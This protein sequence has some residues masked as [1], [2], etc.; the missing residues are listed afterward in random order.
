MLGMR[1]FFHRREQRER[2]LERELRAHLDLESEDLEDADAARRAFGNLARAREMVREEWGFMWLERF[3]KNL[4][5]AFR[6]M[7]RSP[8]FTAIAIAT[9][10]LGLGATSAMFTIVNTALLEPLQYRDPGRLYI[11]RTVPPAE[12]KLARDFPLNGVQ[13]EIWRTNSRLCESL[14]LVQYAEL[15]LVGSGDPATLPALNVTE[16]FFRTL[17]AQPALGRDFLPEDDRSPHAILSDALWRSRFHA[18]PSILG[19]TIQLNGEQYIIVGVMPAGLHLPQGDQWGGFFGPDKAPLVFRPMLPWVRRPV[20]NLNYNGLVRLKPGVSREQAMAEVNALLGDI[21][22]QYDLPTR[23]TLIPMRDQVTRGA[24]SALWLLLAAVG[25]VLLI[26]CVN[27]GNLML[28]RTTGRVREAGIRLA[29]GASRGNLFA[30]VLEEALLLVTI[31]GGLG[32]MV[33]N[34]AL[35]LLGAAA[36]AG[37]PRIDEIQID[38]RVLLFILCAIALSTILCGLVP[39]WRLS[40]TAPLESLKN[41]SAAFT[42][43]A[44]KLRF[45]ESMVGVEVALSTVL[46]IGGGLLIASFARVMSVQKGFEVAHIVT[47]YAS[48]LNPKYKKGVNAQFVERILP[49]LAELPGVDS[50]AAINDLPL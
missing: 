14:A 22:R 41:G 19:R 8:G 18:D 29:V 16:D 9:L 45:R 10:A 33:A 27:I 39:A 15:T 50:A 30:L 7:R 43:G 31:G 47:Q 5:Y 32:L 44:G 4:K 48:F 24:R 35:K 20:G 37:I 21:Y 6:Q 49:Q 23:I 2:D 40:K 3:S 46:L 36:P 28:V 11:A 25:V 38:S 17:G 42:E 26:V 34:F 1:W 13:F 12:S